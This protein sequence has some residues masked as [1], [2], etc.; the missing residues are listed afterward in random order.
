M[1][2][3]GASQTRDIAFKAA[4][5]EVIN[6]GKDRLVIIADGSGSQITGGQFTAFGGFQTYAVNNQDMVVE[7]RPES[8]NNALSARQT[9]GPNWKEI[10]EEG[11]PQACT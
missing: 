6:R 10:V 4:A 5:I 2:E 1:S 3:C 9:L 11:A 7:L 8:D